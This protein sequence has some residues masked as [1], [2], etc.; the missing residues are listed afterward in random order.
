MS[1]EQVQ[2][3]ATATETEFAP[4]D[5]TSLLRKEFKPATDERAGRIEQAQLDALGVYRMHRDVHPVARERHGVPRREVP[6][7]LAVVVPRHGR[8]L[9]DEDADA[10]ARDG[11][12]GGRL[13]HAR[14]GRGRQVRR[15]R[16]KMLL[17]R[18]P[19]CKLLFRWRLRRG[20][21]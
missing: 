17:L 4:D 7:A 8:P 6:A 11:G 15:W 12:R 16:K 21:A 3:G 14:H 2:T 13:V 5:F 9:A 1:T 18:P 20:W 19:L 10:R